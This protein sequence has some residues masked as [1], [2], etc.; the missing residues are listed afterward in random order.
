MITIEFNKKSYVIIMPPEARG[1]EKC[2]K[3]SFCTTLKLYFSMGTGLYHLKSF[4]I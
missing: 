3:M 2:E 1:S 4:R